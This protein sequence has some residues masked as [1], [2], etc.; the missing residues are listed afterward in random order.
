MIRALRDAQIT[1][2]LGIQAAVRVPDCYWIRI[3]RTA[4]LAPLR[5]VRE[6]GSGSQGEPLALVFGD[7]AWIPFGGGDKVRV[8]TT[9]TAGDPVVFDVEW[10]DEPAIAP[11]PLP[12]PRPIQLLADTV[13][14]VAATTYTDFFPE[15]VEHREARRL[16][17]LFTASAI[18]GAATSWV[19]G[20]AGLFVSG[21]AAGSEFMQTA[22]LTLGF[23]LG[24][25]ASTFASGVRGRIVVE[26][27]S[28]APNADTGSTASGS[29]D[30]IRNHALPPILKGQHIPLGGDLSATLKFKLRG[31]F[32]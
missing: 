12:A 24:Y 17:L 25:A 23:Q 27:G 19:I 18:S 10:L 4:G 15:I 20:M 3:V 11:P 7:D 30:A 21:E 16:E 26:P 8:E 32:R 29:R 13:A 22:N 1:P 14:I 28:G 5:L 9:A 2:S 31:Y 6:R